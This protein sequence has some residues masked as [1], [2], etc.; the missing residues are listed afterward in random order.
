MSSCCNTEAILHHWSKRV[1]QIARS[2]ISYS[3]RKIQLP[4]AWLMVCPQH[5]RH[6]SLP[7]A[8]LLVLCQT[9][10]ASIFWAIEDDE[11]SRATDPSTDEAAASWPQEAVGNY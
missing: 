11:Q 6:I 2:D 5:H 10:C 7:T 1:T 8:N 9:C 3:C 4:A